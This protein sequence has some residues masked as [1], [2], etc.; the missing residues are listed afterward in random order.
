MKRQ[1]YSDFEKMIWEIL[2][3]IPKGKVTSYSEIARFA[4]KRL[5]WRAVGNAVGKNPFAPRV[6]CHR[7]IRKDGSLGGYSG[8]I[9]KKIQLL[10]KEGIEVI[11]G[12]VACFLDKY[13]SF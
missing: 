11:N 7:V 12:K 6:P 5:A 13:H 1:K 9:S 3:K 4:G 10:K 2:K 8:G